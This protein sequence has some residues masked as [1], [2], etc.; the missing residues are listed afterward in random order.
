MNPSLAWYAMM[1]LFVVTSLIGMAIAYDRYRWAMEAVPIDEVD[2][3]QISVSQDDV[4]KVVRMYESARVEH[5][6]LMGGGALDTPWFDLGETTRSEGPASVPVGS[7]PLP[8]EEPP[9]QQFY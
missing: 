3:Q 9:V 8:A 6:R 4:A 7:A 5:R 2:I 1:A